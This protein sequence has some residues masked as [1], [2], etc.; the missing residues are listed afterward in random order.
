MP[1]KFKEEAILEAA[2]VGISRVAGVIVSLPAEDR[3]T[4]FSAAE[5][6]YCKT[7]QDMGYGE[8]QARVWAASL[9][10][11]LRTEVSELVEAQL[12]KLHNVA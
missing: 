7:V 2:Y 4:A 11:R 10:V 12:S 9:T 1:L 3:L 6:S 5:R 8:A